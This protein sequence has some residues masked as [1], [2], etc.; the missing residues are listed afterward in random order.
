MRTYNL[1]ILAGGEKGPLSDETGYFNKAMLPIHGKPMLEW[2]IDAFEGS[3]LIE[4]IV[5]VGD[6]SLKELDC[7]N[8]VRKRIFGGINVIHRLVNA[9]AYIKTMIYHQKSKHGGYLISF[10]DAVFLTSEIVKKTLES[11][12]DDQS[13][14]TLHYIEK[15][16]F[17][18]AGISTKRTYLPVGDQL[19]TGS[20]IYYIKKFSLVTKIIPD[21]VTA[22]K[23]RKD[24]HR[25]LK[26]F[27]CEG[28][29]LPEIETTLSYKLKCRFRIKVNPF[30]EMGMDVDKPSDLKLAEKLLRQVPD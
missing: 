7:I 22:R 9:V 28:K 4:N 21:L 10:C 16:T 15:S 12:D 25:L 13:D 2:V 26:H 30:P 24:P 17:E 6:K 5:V 14:I 8:R 19:F 27:E 1:I 3:G 29:T 20:T 11:M 18:A 23:I